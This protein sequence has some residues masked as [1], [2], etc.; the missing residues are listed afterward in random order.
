MLTFGFAAAVLWLSADKPLSEVGWSAA[1]PNYYAMG[2]DLNTAF[3]VSADNKAKNGTQCRNNDNTNVEC[4]L[5][6]SVAFI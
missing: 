6:I 2:S 1:T 5:M 4:R 3:N